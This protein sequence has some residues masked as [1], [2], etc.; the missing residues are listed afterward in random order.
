MDYPARQTRFAEKSEEAHC[1]GFLVTRLPNV[2]YLCGFSGSAGV[3]AYAKG[4][5]AFFTDGRYTQ[6]AGREVSGPKVLIG[7]RS[8]LAMAAEWISRKQAKAIGIEAEHMSIAVRAKLG[9]LVKS[10]LKPTSGLVERLRTIKDA[11]ELKLIRRAVLLGSSLFPTAVK[12]LRPGRTEAEVAARM[13]YRARTRGADAMAFETIVAAGVNSAL[14]H[15]RASSQPIP[16]T[17]FVVL[18]FGVILSGYCSDMTRTVWVGKANRQARD[19]YRAVL[20][21]QLAAIAAVRPGVR[22]GEVDQAARKVLQKAGL[23]RYFTH[24]TGHGVGLEIHEAPR[25][26]RNEEVQ[27]MPGMVITIEPGAY[28]AGKGGVRIEDMLVVTR[29]GAEVLTPTTKEF[30]GV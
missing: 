25:L 17:G 16:N 4:S 26:A 6:Q 12:A 10:R 20:D 3:L 28:I 11:Y 15:W 5:F 1:D 8:A 27:L 18:D 14:P 13:E 7:Q 19:M 2:R 30:I 21:S 24:S 22:A 29:H 9:K 23:A